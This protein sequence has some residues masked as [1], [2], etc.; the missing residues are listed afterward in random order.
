MN[1]QTFTTH[2]SLIGEFLAIRFTADAVNSE[3]NALC[4]VLIVFGQGDEV[5]FF[6][7]FIWQ[8]EN[9]EEQFDNV[10]MMG[11]RLVNA[12]CGKRYLLE[13]FID[14]NCINNNVFEFEFH[15]DVPW[16]DFFSQNTDSELPRW[17]FG[18]IGIFWL[19]KIFLVNFLVVDSV[20]GLAEIDLA[21]LILKMV[22]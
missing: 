16:D 5:E 15:H 3:L 9:G 18:V 13:S 2:I 19:E 20:E 6:A 11:G 22:N 4:R 7:R 10:G 12:S 14:A 1:G 17:G 21:L 8:T